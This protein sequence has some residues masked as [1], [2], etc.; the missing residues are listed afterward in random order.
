[1]FLRDLAHE[2]T[3]L[4]AA[5]FFG[6]CGTAVVLFRGWWRRWGWWRWCWFRLDWR[7]WRRWSSH[8]RRRR[9]RYDRLCRFFFD[10]FRRRRFSS[11]SASTVKHGHD[12]VDFNRLA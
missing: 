6:G 9:W 3:R 12:G 5:Q 1:M 7:W 2:R 4:R 10:D 8:W 11:H